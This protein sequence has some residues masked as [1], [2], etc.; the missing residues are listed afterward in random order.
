MLILI[1]VA[2]WVYADIRKDERMVRRD[3]RRW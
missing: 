3:E 2:F 1:A